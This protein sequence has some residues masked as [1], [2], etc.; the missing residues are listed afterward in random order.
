ME[1]N[2]QIVGILL[3][4]G[5]SR[6]FGSQKA[7]ANL[8]DKPM[9]MYSL[10]VLKQTS[11]KVIVTSH[12][13]ISSQLARFCHEKIIEDVAAYRGLGPLA[14]L[15]SGMI[16]ETGDWYTVLPCDTPKVSG[17][18]MNRI[19]SYRSKDID[20]IIP[21]IKGKIQPLIGVYS[22]RMTP[23]IKELL[24][25]ENL[26]MTS[27]LELGRIRYLTDVELNSMEEE[28]NNVN[29]PSDL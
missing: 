26:R 9:F 10:E 25:K 28:F 24:D 29:Y 16:E 22:A 23:M 21:K 12:P 8:L 7:F 19:L 5:V 1:K 13:K 18:L 3:A 20:A 4:G 14:G 17:K 11:D 6:R 2:E 27:L 15:Y